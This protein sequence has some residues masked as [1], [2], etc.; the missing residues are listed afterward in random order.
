MPFIDPRDKPSFLT[1]ASN[2]GQ[3][4]TPAKPSLPEKK[5]ESLFGGKSQ[6]SRFEFEKSLRKDKDIREQLAKELRIR[7]Y[8]PEMNATIKEMKEK[9]PKIFGGYIDKR[10]AERLEKK[11]YWDE[12]HEFQEKAR[13]GITPQES[14]E[15]AKTKIKN[16]FLRSLFGVD[17]K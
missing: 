16:K 17:K 13:D 10:E 1:K 11:Q 9:V 15:M 14:K 7:P 4:K 12:K 3:E 6:V 2:A 8:S 5:D